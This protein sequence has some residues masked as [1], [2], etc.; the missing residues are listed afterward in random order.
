MVSCKSKQLFLSGGI[1]V[2]RIKVLLRRIK[3][4]FRLIKEG[5]NTK[6]LRYYQYV[7]YGNMGFDEYEKF[8]DKKA[9]K[10]NI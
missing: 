2:K 6:E 3:L 1:E 8:M 9:R 5:Y 4:Y 7:L 10:E